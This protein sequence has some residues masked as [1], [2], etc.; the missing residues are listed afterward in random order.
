MVMAIVLLDTF[1]V[2]IA[3][4]KS[5]LLIIIITETFIRKESPVR[6]T[7]PNSSLNISLLSLNDLNKELIGKIGI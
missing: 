4:F 5:V 3:N 2:K 1:E 7:L 6:P